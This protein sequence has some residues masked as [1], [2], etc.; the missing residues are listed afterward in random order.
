MK[1]E[2]VKLKH[3]NTLKRALDLAKDTDG[4]TSGLSVPVEENAYAYLSYENYREA[5]KRFMKY[6]KQKAEIVEMLRQRFL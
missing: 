4:L 6:E 3:A 2:P 5:M 1:M